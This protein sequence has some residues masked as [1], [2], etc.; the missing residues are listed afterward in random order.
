MV[1]L[2]DV[3]L[4]R[5]DRTLLKHATW[6]LGPGDRVGIVGVN[7]AGKTSVLGLV[8][9]DAA[10]RRSAGSSTAALSRSRT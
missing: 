5:G 8:A 7:G 2:E 9:G 6:R 10:A 1:D 3:D 4:A